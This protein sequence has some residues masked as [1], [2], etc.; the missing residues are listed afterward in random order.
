MS[1]KFSCPKLL[2]RRGIECVGSGLDRNSGYTIQSWSA[3]FPWSLK[4]LK[5]TAKEYFFESPGK[6]LEIWPKPSGPG[7]LIACKKVMESP[8]IHF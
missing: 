8:A 1:E 4:I 3:K 6:V 7:I 2:E 5:I